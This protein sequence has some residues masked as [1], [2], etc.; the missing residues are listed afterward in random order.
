MKQI[1]LFLNKYFYCA[2]IVSTLPGIGSGLC[3]LK[4]LPDLVMPYILAGWI[5][6]LYCCVQLSVRNG[7]GNVVFEVTRVLAGFAVGGFIGIVVGGVMGNL[8]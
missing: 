8:A 4:V 5:I 7:N 1:R 2:M 6:I 3:S